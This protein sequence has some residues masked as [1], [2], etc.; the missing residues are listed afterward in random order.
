M[1]ALNAAGFL[2]RFDVAAYGH[3]GDPQQLREVRDPHYAFALDGV[4][5]GGV[6]CCLKHQGLSGEPRQ[7]WG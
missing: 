2:E 1:N 6:A 5:D 7:T 4:D 3:G